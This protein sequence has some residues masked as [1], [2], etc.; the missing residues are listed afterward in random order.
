M[1]QGIKAKVKLSK[2]LEDHIFS[3]TLKKRELEALYRRCTSYQ[4]ENPE[5]WSGD[6]FRPYSKYF[7][8]LSALKAKA[9]MNE[10]DQYGYLDDLS[11]KSVH[12]VDF[13]AGT[14][15]GTLGIYDFFRE[16]KW[17]IENARAVD[18]NLKPMRWALEYFDDFLDPAPTVTTEI[19]LPPRDSTSI[20][21]AIDV[22]NE[23]SAFQEGQTD[24]P[25]F[26]FIRDWLDQMP[27]KSI[28]IWIEPANKKTN[29]RFLAFRDAFKTHA[30]ILLPC[31]HSLICPALAQKEWC[32]EDRDYLAPSIYWNLVKELGFR[33]GV[34]S[35]SFLALG[36]MSTR[37]QPTDA[38]IVSRDLRN[39]GRCDKWLCA[40][41]KRWKAGL[42]NRHQ[43]DTNAS[44]FEGLRGD[45]IDC[46]STGIKTP[47]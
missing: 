25:D 12:L 38:R 31:T 6:L 9:C 27:P 46:S 14:L 39:K 28:F 41:G 15:G 35:Y 29:Q 42:L 17:K 18:Q 45:I 47:D 10:L 3:G 44:F 37:F 11:R 8:F 13:G 5:E 33:R 21:L 32:H 36:K 16:K 20:F 19:G 2:A 34:L 4:T 43:N 7:G 23:F 24:S 30:D 22:L 26:Q 40:N 1:K